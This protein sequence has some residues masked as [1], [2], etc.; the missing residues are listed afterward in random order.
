MSSLWNQF[1]KLK[2]TQNMRAL[3][4]PDFSSYLLKIGNG[5]EHTNDKKE[6]HIPS[7]INIPFTDDNTSLNALI[8][9]PE[10]KT[11]SRLLIRYFEHDNTDQVSAASHVKFPV[12]QTLNK[13]LQSV[14]NHVL[15]LHYES[16]DRTARF[17]WLVC[18]H[19]CNLSEPSNSKFLVSSLLETSAEVMSRMSP[20]ILLYDTKRLDERDSDQRDC[21]MPQ[22]ARSH[23]GLH[24]Y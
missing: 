12:A 18:D 13:N 19:E 6:I 1:G 8:D 15:Q 7:K 16:M 24:I 20:S 22:N 14:R 9:I 5:I 3:L 2:L 11:V 10:D 23:P 17:V 21:G 4:D